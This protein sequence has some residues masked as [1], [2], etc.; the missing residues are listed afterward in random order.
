[1]SR[2]HIPA[3]LDIERPSSWNFGPTMVRG[4]HQC[5]FAET[6]AAPLARQQWQAR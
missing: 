4:V 5:N 2:K 1:M 3:L 6:V